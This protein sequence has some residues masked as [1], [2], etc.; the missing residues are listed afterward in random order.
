MAGAAPPDAVAVERVFA[1]HNIAT[2]MGTAQAAAVADAGGRAARAPGRD[3]HPDRGQGGRHRQR[4]GRQGAGD[5]DGHADP[6][7]RPSP[8]SPPTPPTRSPWRSATSG[9][10]APSTACR[11]ALPSTRRWPPMIASVSGAV[12]RRLGLDARSL[13]VG[14]VGLAVH[15]HPGTLAGLASAPRRALATTH[16][17]PRGLAH[18]VRVRRQRRARGLRQLQTVSGVGPRLAQAV[19]AVHAPDAVRGAVATD[20]SAR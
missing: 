11:A 9:A 10:V 5:R 18:P 13:E 20:E 2:I 14:G 12:A 6:R 7:A 4:P 3:A 16:G 15:A 19:L 8:R 17:R 1:Q